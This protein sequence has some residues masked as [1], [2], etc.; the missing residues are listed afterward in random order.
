MN[1]K[2]AGNIDFNWNFSTFFFFFFWILN[3]FL[4]SIQQPGVTTDEIDKFIHKETIEANAYPSPLLYCTFP[5]SVCTSVN[6]VVC[7]GIPDDRPLEDG[8]IINIDITVSDS[9][10]KMDFEVILPIN[11]NSIRI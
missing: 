10:I 2:N 9:L 1:P 7:H 8:D 5:K 6:N 11:F 3:L 4:V